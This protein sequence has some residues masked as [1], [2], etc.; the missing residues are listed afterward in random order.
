MPESHTSG[1]SSRV[2]S[3]YADDPDFQD[4][5]EL[6]FESIESQSREFVEAR[7]Q[8]QWEEL[9]T[10]A[11]QLKGAGSGYGFPGLS[12]KAWALETVCQQK[13]EAA[14]IPCLDDLLAYI[15]RI[16]S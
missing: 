15:E 1:E 12:E 5:L 11:H 6:F 8:Q 3:E 10:K 4:L 2:Y 14:I 16:H 9:E 7:E 13:N